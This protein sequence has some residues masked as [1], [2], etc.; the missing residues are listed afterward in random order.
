MVELTVGLAIVGILMISLAMSLD[1]FAKLNRS[2]LV[3][4]QCIS[5]GQAQLESLAVRGESISD[6]DF[7]RLWPRLAVSIERSGGTGQWEG[8]ELVKVTTSGKSFGR[9]V[10]VQLSRYVLTGKGR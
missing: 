1:A 6:E 7:A 9:E 5:A 10:K 4:Q 8:M 2:Q 3:R